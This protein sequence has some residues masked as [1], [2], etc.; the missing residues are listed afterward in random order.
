MREY[1]HRATT[2]YI[3]RQKNWSR[4]SEFNFLKNILFNIFSCV[5]KFNTH[6]KVLVLIFFSKKNPFQQ[7]FTQCAALKIDRTVIRQTCGHLILY[8][9]QN[10]FFFAFELLFLKWIQQNS[11]YFW[12]NIL[13]RVH[14][15][16][17]LANF[18]IFYTMRFFAIII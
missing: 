9:S 6:M 16:L 10:W 12:K 5:K 18:N 4:L 8:F 11:S 13:V 7:Y 17:I 2:Q 15:N 3:V 1:L 14:L